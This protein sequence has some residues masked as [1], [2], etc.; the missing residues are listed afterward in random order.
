MSRSTME[1]AS[2]WDWG[3]IWGVVGEE[4]S[5]FLETSI[6]PQESDEPGTKM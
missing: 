5:K 4:V 3:N 2:K 1:L 6:A